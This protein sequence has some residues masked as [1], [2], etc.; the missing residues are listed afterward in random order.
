M[1]DFSRTDILRVLKE[2]IEKG[3]VLIRK[4]PLLDGR[5]QVI[6]EAHSERRAGAIADSMEDAIVAVAAELK[7]REESEN[8]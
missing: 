2:L 4:S 1:A 3:E 5:T 8:L 6:W 7:R